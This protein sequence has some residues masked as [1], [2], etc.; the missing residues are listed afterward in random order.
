[1]AWKVL[2]SRSPTHL[3]LLLHLMLLQ[4]RMG[5]SFLLHPDFSAYVRASF[6]DGTV[7]AITGGDLRVSH[8]EIMSTLE[9]T[10]VQ[11]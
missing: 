4:L 3:L 9:D 5:S 6:E 2:S 1:M 8:K 10:L 11:E 7:Y